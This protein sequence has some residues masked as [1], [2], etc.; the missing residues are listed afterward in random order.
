MPAP[1]YASGD[2]ERNPAGGDGCEVQV[3]NRVR[4]LL[5][6]VPALVVGTIEVLSD[7]LLDAA[8]PFPLDTLLVVAVTLALGGAFATLAFRRIDALTGALR[9]RNQ[10]LEARETSA[11][12]LH[13]VSVAIAS[14]TDIDR[15]LDAI[16]T[17]TRELLEVDA[18]ILLL[19]GPDGR[20]VRRA[21]SAIPGALLA[22]PAIPGANPGDAPETTNPGASADD[23]DWRL[24]SASAARISCFISGSG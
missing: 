10:E 21:A 7:E 19:A 12:A 1:A 22:I 20:L 16:V 24:M 8:F 11:R 14:L 3:P 9:R 15:V 18:V 23:S 4:W 2:A 13:R 6:I 17:H 5:I